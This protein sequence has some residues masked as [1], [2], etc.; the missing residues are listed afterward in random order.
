MNKG[1]VSTNMILYCRNW[2][3]TVR[4]YRDLLQLPLLFS[5]DWFV[6][7]ALTETSRLSIADERRASVKSCGG[8]GITVALE[9]DRIEAARERMQAMGAAPTEIRDHPW[10]ARVLYVFD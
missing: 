4:F 5:S 2:G 10:G 3:E 1:L 7:F 9:V 6:E 8:R